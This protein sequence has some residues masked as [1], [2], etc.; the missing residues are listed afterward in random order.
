MPL[1]LWVFL[2]FVAIV[3]PPLALVA[4]VFGCAWSDALGRR[5]LPSYCAWSEHRD[6]ERWAAFRTAGRRAW[7]RTRDRLD[8]ADR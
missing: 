5:L 8:A 2:P 7:R 6:A 4:L 3:G 1:V